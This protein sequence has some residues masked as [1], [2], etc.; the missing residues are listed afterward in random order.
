MV[1][2]KNLYF[3]NFFFPIAFLIGI[4]IGSSYSLTFQQEF[5]L[6]WILVTGVAIVLDLIITWRN[7]RDWKREK[8]EE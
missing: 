5:H 8:K 6:D 4:F 7:S 2:K 1:S 3:F